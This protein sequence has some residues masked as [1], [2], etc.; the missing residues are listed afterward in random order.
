MRANVFFK[1]VGPHTPVSEIGQITRTLL[2][3]IVVREGIV[4]EQKIPLKVHFGEKGNHTYLRSDNYLGIIDFLQKRG[5]ET[6]YM[7]TSVMYGGQRYNKELHLQTAAEH[8]F[9]QI[10]V[11]IADGEQGEAFVEV[12][13]ALN[14]FKS[15]KIGREFL[16]YGQV[17]VLSHF[18]GH[19]FAGFGGAIKQLS[20]GHASKGGKLAM[21]MGIKPRIRNRNCRHCGLCVQRCQEQAIT[22]GAKACIDHR[23]CVGCGACVAICPHRAISI[24][25]PKG[26]LNALTQGKKFREKLVEYAYAAQMGKKNIYFNFAMNI[27]RGCDCEPRKMKPLM[28]DFGIFVSTDPVAIDKVCLDMARERGKDFKG[29]EQLRYAEKV[30][31]GSQQYTLIQV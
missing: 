7:E 2:D 25:S 28:D 19:F 1:P 22:L 29:G 5:I 8:G 4:L 14:H 24:F 26:I 13:V 15:C 23:K 12:P 16:G 17:I 20:M 30:G 27:T 21:H 18:K 10:P 31:L 11:V 6:C 3:E 9:N